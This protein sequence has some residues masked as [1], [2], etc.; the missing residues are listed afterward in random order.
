MFCWSEPDFAK[1]CTGCAVFFCDISQQVLFAQHPMS[2]VFSLGALTRMHE[3][4]E[5]CIG[6]T[7]SAPARTAD[8]PILLIIRLLNSTI[9][10]AGRVER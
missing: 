6:A 9:G 10:A 1:G 7:K 2:H 4:A 3:T 5:D 8:I